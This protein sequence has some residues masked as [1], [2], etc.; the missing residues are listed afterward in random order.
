MEVAGVDMAQGMVE[1]GGEQGERG[2]GV[3]ETGGARREVYPQGEE[4]PLTEE[5]AEGDQVLGKI[6][7]LQREERLF[8]SF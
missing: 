8:V 7:G 2:R 6:L 5:E 3:E 1:C 4:V